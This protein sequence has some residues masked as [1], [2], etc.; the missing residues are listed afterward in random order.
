MAQAGDRMPSVAETIAR[1]KV[2]AAELAIYWLCQAGFAFKSSS[3]E[4]VYIDPYFSDV[5]ERLIGFKRMMAFPVLAEDASAD[6]IVCTHEHLDHTD[7]DALPVLARNPRTQFAGP[8]ECIKEFTK[9]GI[10]A[11]RCHLLEEGASL[12][13]GSV[14]INA[15]YADHGEL[16]PDALGIVLNFGGIKVYHTGDTAYRPE[17]F[18]PAIKMRPDVLIPCINGAFGNM[19]AQEAALL[20]SL[21]NPRV[22]IPSH[23][24]MFVEQNGEPGVFLRRCK[25]LA[26]Q[27]QAVLMKPGEELLFKKQ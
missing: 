10:P 13:L 25:E 26:P 20:T 5:V 7:T 19:D 24:W 8:I 12:T 18:A 15:V 22:A 1:R 27:S 3:S 9:L 4:I 16:A 21:V 6:L 17:E 23:F 2:N 11:G 14:E